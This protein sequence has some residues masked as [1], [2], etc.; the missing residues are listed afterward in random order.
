AVQTARLATQSLDDLQVIY[1]G[2]LGDTTKQISAAQAQ[3][4]FVILSAAAAPA[5]AAAGGRGG[6]PGAGG[7]GGGGRGGFGPGPNR[8]LGAAAVAVVNLDGLSAEA[9]AALNAP[10]ANATLL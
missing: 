10:P 4:R 3:G 6:A 2:V 7:R 1:G 5:V 9:I 8:F